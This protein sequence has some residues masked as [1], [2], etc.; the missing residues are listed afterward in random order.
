MINMSA[1]KVET[2]LQEIESLD[3]EK[4]MMKAE[5]TNPACVTLARAAA[6]QPPKMWSLEMGP[7]Y[8]IMTV[9]YL[10]STI[11]G[12]GKQSNWWVYK[13]S[14]PLHAYF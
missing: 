3:H 7:I 1:P 10:V 2:T 14:S 5:S 13:N 8:L 6:E 4:P 11:Q 12:Y 9:G